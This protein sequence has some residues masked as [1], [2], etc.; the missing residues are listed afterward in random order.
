MTRKG[1]N[2][3][4]GATVYSFFV[5]FVMITPY[6]AQQEIKADTEL[7]DELIGAYELKIQGQTGAFIFIEEEG[8]LKG[9][10][11]GEEPSLLELMEG[12]E[13]TFIG[14]LPDGTEQLFRFLRNEEGKVT[15]CL[16]SI[17]ASGLVV[18][19]FKV[20]KYRQ[21]HCPKILQ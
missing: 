12:Q 10:P 4:I 17:P 16:L 7:L 5:L 8:K 6:Y 15:K 11:A 1:K 21:S 19:M 9:A 2:S 13:M 3:L 18:D 20:E 14:Y